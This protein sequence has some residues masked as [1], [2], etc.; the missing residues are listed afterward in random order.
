MNLEKL[1]TNKILIILFIASLIIRSI[2]GVITYDKMGSSGFG[3]DW[4]YIGYAHQL[5]KGNIIHFD[6]TSPYPGYDKV[7]SE[8]YGPGLPIIITPVIAIFGDNYVYIYILNALLQS[9]A[10]IFVFLLGKEYFNKKVGL[11]SAAWITFYWYHIQYIPRILKET[12]LVLLVILALY[13]FILSIKKKNITNIILTSFIFTYLLHTD[14]RFIFFFPVFLFGYFFLNEWNLKK[15]LRQSLIFCLMVL[16]FMTPWLI[17]NQIKYNQPVLITARLQDRINRLI[18]AEPIHS[19]NFTWDREVVLAKYKKK[20]KKQE[21]LEYIQSGNTPYFFEGVEN[22]IINVIEHWR[23]V[24]FRP[25]YV[26]QG[27]RFAGAWTNRANIL[28][29]LQ[30]GVPLL[31]CV[32]SV[33][34]AFY[35]KNKYAIFLFCMIIVH[36]V[37]H[38]GILLYG[39]ARY[40]VP[41]DVVVIIIGFYGLFVVWDWFQTK[42]QIA[43]K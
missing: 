39:K 20:G 5:V 6:E 36:A 32:V 9:V 37:L 25:G 42:K 27:Y 38:S 30:W 15:G 33:F 18:G 40:R 21:E 41:F 11:L 19:K 7:L 8:S 28:Y 35:K 12:V 16:C 34:I 14:E 23:F 10:V 29:P 1:N 31:L 17:R 22:I 26:M 43:L 13:F 2:F 4:T 24:R 3:D